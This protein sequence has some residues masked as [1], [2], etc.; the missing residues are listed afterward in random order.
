MIRNI[1]IYKLWPDVI[2][3]LRKNLSVCATISVSASANGSMF[4]HIVDVYQVDYADFLGL[5]VDK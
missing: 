4:V 5:G 3:A 1:F 2:A